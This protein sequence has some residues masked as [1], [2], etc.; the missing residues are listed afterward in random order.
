MQ[1]TPLEPLL[2]HNQRGTIPFKPARHGGD[3]IA[4]PRTQR[5]AVSPSRGV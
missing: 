2:G 5:I 3:A 1:E 4:K